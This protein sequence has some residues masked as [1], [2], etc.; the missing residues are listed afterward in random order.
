MARRPSSLTLLVTAT[1][2]VAIAWYVVT[3]RRA[4]HRFLAA[5][6]TDDA[7]EFAATTDR[8]ALREH[9]REDFEAVIR[10]KVKIRAAEPGPIINGLV[11]TMVDFLVSPK[12]LKQVVSAFSESNGDLGAGAHIAY[13]Y[14]GPSQV[15]V[16]LRAAAEPDSDAGIFSFA[17]EGA[18]WRL[19]RVWSRRLAALT[20]GQ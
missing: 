19:T 3:P 9:A 18:S 11:G 8:A 13:R 5:V 1:V 4:F 16:L 6:A 15:D 7:A 20:G 14:R 10:S 12:G 2:V 17:R